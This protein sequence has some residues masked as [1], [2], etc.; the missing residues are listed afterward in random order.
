MTFTLDEANLKPLKEGAAALGVSLDSSQLEQFQRYYE[1]VIDW[2]RRVNLTSVTGWE[3]FQIRHFADSLSVSSAVPSRLLA[4]GRVLDVGSGAGFPGLPLKI[5]F[6]CLRMTLLEATA[7]KVAFLQHII[8]VLVL[9]GADVIRARAELAAHD[10]DLREAFDLVLSRAV[11]PLSVLAE[12]TLPFGRVGSL[13]VLH[14]K[15]DIDD[16]IRRAQRAIE[17]MGG[18][19]KEVMEV[20]TGGLLVVLEKLMPAPEDYPRRPGIPSKRPL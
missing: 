20:A 18:R 16:E 15:V 17:A 8:D 7:K 3:Q 5:A 1:E 6:P 19:L 9:P 10:H 12:L 13:V 14:K 11:A 2:N 4:T